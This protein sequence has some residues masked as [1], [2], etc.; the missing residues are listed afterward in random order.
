MLRTRWRDLVPCLIGHGAG[1]DPCL[2]FPVTSWHNF[3]SSSVKT[4]SERLLSARLSPTP[5]GRAADACTLSAICLRK[6]RQISL[7]GICSPPC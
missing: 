5:R 6:E 1:S 3:H 2:V 7:A 4:L